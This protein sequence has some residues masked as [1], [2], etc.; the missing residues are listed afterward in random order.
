MIKKTLGEKATSLILASIT[1][2][3]G[4]LVAEQVLSGEQ[5]T[6]IQGLTGMILGGG[7][8]SVITVIYVLRDLLPKKTAQNIVN[9]IGVDKVNKVFNVVDEVQKIVL[10]LTN[11]VDTLSNELALE[12]AAKQELGAYENISQDL[13]DKLKV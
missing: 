5:L 11:K 9:N 4:I 13:K 1:A 2:I 12:R 7:S 6:S 10:D 3:G 8:F